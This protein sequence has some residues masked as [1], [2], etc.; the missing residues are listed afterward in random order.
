MEEY[1]G[2]KGEPIYLTFNPN[3]F[4]EPGH[5]LIV[6]F[7]QGELLFIRH[8]ER[9]IELPGGK[10]ER[11]ETPLA[12]AVR[13]VYEEAGASLCE[14]HLIGQYLLPSYTPELV[15]NIYVAKVA[16][17]LPLPGESDTLGPIRFP[18]IPTSVKEDDRFSPY[19]KDAIYPRLLE[20]LGI[21]SPNPI[22]IACLEEGEAWFS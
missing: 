10:I 6:P 1:T 19:M 22:A 21:T 3:E 15:K 12:A 13:E 2:L 18:S 11:G 20:V 5:V 7:Y 14:I 9:G 16:D 8:R 4:K 17:L